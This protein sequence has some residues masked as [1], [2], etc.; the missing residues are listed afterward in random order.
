MR[1]LGC[2]AAGLTAGNYS[3]DIWDMG[4][5]FSQEP[6]SAGRLLAA[7][8]WWQDRQ[9]SQAQRSMIGRS[10]VSMRGRSKGGR[11]PTVPHLDAG[12]C[13]CASCR[14]ASGER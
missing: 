2:L 4:D 6:E 9:V 12:Y 8:R 13:R 5:D 10:L 3:C 1:Y 7:L 14:H 11:R